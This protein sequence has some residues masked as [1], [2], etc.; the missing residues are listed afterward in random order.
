MIKNYFRLTCARHDSSHEGEAVGG[1]FG[2]K[3][4]DEAILNEKVQIDFP[5]LEINEDGDHEDHLHE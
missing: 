2:F 3:H 4:E 5:M 1:G